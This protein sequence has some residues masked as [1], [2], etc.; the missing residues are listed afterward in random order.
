MARSK[1]ECPLNVRD[2]YS[3]VKYPYLP[4]FPS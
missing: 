3:C 2:P 1:S 4:G